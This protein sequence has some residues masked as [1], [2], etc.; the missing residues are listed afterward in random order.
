[1]TAV[2]AETPGEG[3]FVFDPATYCSEMLPPHRGAT[4]ELPTNP[5]CQFEDPF[6]MDNLKFY[7]PEE[8]MGMVLELERMNAE[9]EGKEGGEKIVAI[10]GT[11]GTIAM[12]KEGGELVPRLDAATLL[13]EL[14]ASK[15]DRF[16]AA[17]IQL[18]TM[19]DSALMHP[20]VIADTVLLMSAT[21]NSMSESLRKNFAGFM[22]THGTD[23]LAQSAASSRMM[24]GRDVPFNTAFVGAQKTIEDVPNDVA[25]NIDG[26]LTT[27]ALA[28]D[29]PAA[30][31][32][33]V[34]MN[35]TSGAAM[36][37]VGIVKVSDS[38]VEAF[39]SPL[40][41]PVLN[42]ANFAAAG[43]GQVL[44]NFM[45]DGKRFRP[46]IVRGNSEVEVIQAE[47]GVHPDHDRDRI[48]AAGQRG[49]LAAVVAV[50]YGGFTFHVAN[51]AAISEEAGRLRVP[52]FAVNPF[53]SG[54]TMHEYGPAH[55]IRQSGAIPV[56]MMP[57]ALLA[58][59]RVGRAIYGA[60]NDGFVQF[61]CSDYVGEMPTSNVRS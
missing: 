10:I 43:I 18:P 22:I 54:S 23:T 19:V 59:I 57:A 25:A 52:V 56:T 37:Q 7:R 32:H 16:R 20:D 30:T 27:L 46:L 13:G 4:Y 42:M 29:D 38:R 5:G 55:H 50:T 17:S 60:D 49:K 35:G 33:F 58:K 39:A 36:T 9:I 47:Q 2:P 6:D 28:H 12:V 11:G 8:A 51:F 61:I 45:R 1:M 48:K 24:L 40:H 34:F 14:P 31:H 3:V 15:R 41:E 26:A 44:A 21:Y 53:P